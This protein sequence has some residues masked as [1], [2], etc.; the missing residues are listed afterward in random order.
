MFVLATKSGNGEQYQFPSA[1]NLI[2]DKT[3]KRKFLPKRIYTY[4]HKKLTNKIKIVEV[5]SFFI[6]QKGTIIH[7]I[8]VGNQLEIRNTKL[9][10]IFL[11]NRAEFIL[12]FFFFL[13]NYKIISNYTHV[14]NESNQNF[15]SSGTKV[16]DKF[17]RDEK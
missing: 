9:F 4:V 2:L 12:F 13:T 10:Y 7:T 8:S 16:T 3:K 14:K 6:F 1:S 15:A 17:K 5:N 11:K